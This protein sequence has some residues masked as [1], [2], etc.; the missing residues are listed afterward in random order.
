MSDLSRG[1]AHRSHVSGTSRPSSSSWLTVC[2]LTSSSSMRWPGGTLPPAFMA[3]GKGAPLK[4]FTTSGDFCEQASVFDTHL[5]STADVLSAGED[6]M[7]RLYN[8][9]PGDT[10]AFVRRWL[11]A[12]LMYSHRVCRLRQQQQSAAAFVCTSWCS[13]G[14]EL[15]TNSRRKNGGACTCPN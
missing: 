6:A 11:Q 14:E 3:L 4:K 9:K 13:S 10:S 7:L 12:L 2:A 1:R 15:W 8:E 5:A